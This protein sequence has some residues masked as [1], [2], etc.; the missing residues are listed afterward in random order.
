V[1]ARSK[2][3]VCDRSLPGIVGSNPAGDMDVSLVSVVGCQVEVFASGCSLV[4]RSPTQCGMSECDH[5]FSIMR[6]PWPTALLRHGKKKN[7]PIT[8]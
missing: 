8:S 6:K 4:R 2:A 5:E 1:A 7:T 3:W